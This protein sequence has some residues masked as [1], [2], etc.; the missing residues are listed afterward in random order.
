MF[1]V[2][3]FVRRRETFTHS[4]ELARRLSGL[5][6]HL[7]DHDEQI[8]SLVSAIHNLMSPAPIPKKRQIGF[9]RES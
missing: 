9:Q 4:A 6:R 7:A 8:L 2:R 5:E 3:A 1:I